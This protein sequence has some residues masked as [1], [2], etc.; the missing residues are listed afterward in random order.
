MKK[1]LIVLCL[2][3]LLAAIS[4]TAYAEVP[5]GPAKK[6][7]RGL[8]NLFAGA[9]Y[10]VPRQIGKA[11]DENNILGG[12]FVGVPVGIGKG[13]W[14]TAIGLYET[15]TFFLPIPERY[16]PIITDTEFPFQQERE[17]QF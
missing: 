1:V 11:N 14:R 17:Y 16:E 9:L 15:A 3:S 5:D 13:V 8:A 4:H 7:G 2:A 6:F 10:E 12:I